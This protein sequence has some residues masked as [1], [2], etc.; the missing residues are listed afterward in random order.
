MWWH[1]GAGGLS[2][3]AD[4]MQISA[5]C[6]NEHLAGAGRRMIVIGHGQTTTC[7]WQTTIRRSVSSTWPPADDHVTTSRRTA[8]LEPTQVRRRRHIATLARPGLGSDGLD[9]QHAA[10]LLGQLGARLR[11]R[12]EQGEVRYDHRNRKCY[13]KYAGE[14]TQRTDKHSDVRLGRH[15]AVA[16]RRH[17]DD[18]PPQTTH[19]LVWRTTQDVPVVGGWVV[20]MAHHRPTGIEV[21]SLVGLYCMR[22]A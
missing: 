9:G 22:S 16:D 18:S 12:V 4:W 1:T 11:V 17:G 15:I 14:R 5:C 3:G 6:G 20:A 8:H 7:S 13:R 10:P 19:L 21:K 2:C